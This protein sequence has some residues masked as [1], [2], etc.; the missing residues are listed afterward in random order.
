LASVGQRLSSV[1]YRTALGRQSSL[2]LNLQLVEFRSGAAAG[3]AAQQ[4]ESHVVS[5]TFNTRL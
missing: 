3:R 5:A 2:S 4:R 1:G